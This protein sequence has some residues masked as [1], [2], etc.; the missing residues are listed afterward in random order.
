[1][2]ARVTTY[3]LDEARASESIEAFEPAIDRVRELDGF[4]DAL[5]LVERDGN[6][7][8]SLTLWD[9]LDALERSRVTASTARNEAARE[10][11]AEV[12]ST[13]ELEVGIRATVDGE[14]LLQTRGSSA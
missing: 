7:A 8:I 14:A 2:F 3:E 4:V 10:V 13:Y 12:M 9:S 1:M 5:F 11:S 6:H